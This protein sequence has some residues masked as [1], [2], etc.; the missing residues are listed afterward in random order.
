MHVGHVG[1]K[2]EESGAECTSVGCCLLV[3][4]GRAAELGE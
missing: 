3:F 1:V 4:P 2:Q